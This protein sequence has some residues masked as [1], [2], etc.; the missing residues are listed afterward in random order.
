MRWIDAIFAAVYD[1]GGEAKVADIVGHEFVL[2]K[3]RALGRHRNVSQTVWGTL[4]AHTV[5]NSQTVH[6]KNKRAPFVF[7]KSM[8]SKWSLV[9]DWED[10]C[11]EMVNLAKSLKEGPLEETAQL[12]YEFVTFHQAYSYEDFVEGIR[13]IQDEES[14]ELAYAVVPGIFQRIAQKAKVDPSQRYAIFID[15]INR[16]NIAKIFGELITLI[17]ADKRAVYSEDGEKNRVWN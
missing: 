13:P 10:E 8:S 3:A 16:G 12:R 15:E 14:G 4:Q 17:E 11:S 6:I 7:D 2:M 1:L 9:G 5:E